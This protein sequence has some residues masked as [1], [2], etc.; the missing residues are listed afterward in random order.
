M[1]PMMFILV[2]PLAA[3][4]KRNMHRALLVPEILLIIFKY[5]TDDSGN[6]LLPTLAAI[7]RTCRP[8]QR[9]VEEILWYK[10][11]NI[12]ALYNILPTQV[13][14]RES[15]S[16]SLS[17]RMLSGP[18]W[19]RFVDRAS[20]VRVLAENTG[21]RHDQYERCLAIF[22]AMVALRDPLLLTPNLR[23]LE[24]QPS[25]L[26]LNPAINLF[27]SPSLRSLE[28][29]AKLF[30]NHVI[31]LPLVY[32][33]PKLEHL[34]ITGNGRSAANSISS[35]LRGLHCLET[36]ACSTMDN[37]AFIHLAQL[38]KLSY[39][40]VDMR[41]S[42]LNLEGLHDRLPPGSFPSLQTLYWK[43]YSIDS[44]ADIF[45]MPE[46]SPSNQFPNTRDFSLIHDVEAGR[47]F[48]V[49]VGA[50]RREHQLDACDL[51]PLSALKSLRVL[52]L[53]DLGY[54]QLDD[55][56]I[57]T[58][59]STSPELEKLGLGMNG[60]DPMPTSVTFDGLLSLLQHCPK[61]QSLG[62]CVDAED[63]LSFWDTTVRHHHVTH[64]R[65]EG[66][67]LGSRRADVDEMLRRVL[68]GLRTVEESL[69]GVTWRVR[70]M[71][72]LDCLWQMNPP[73]A[74]EREIHSRV[75][76]TDEVCLPICIIA[77]A[78]F[79]RDPPLPDVFECCSRMIK[80][81][82]YLNA[83]VYPLCYI[84]CTAVSGYGLFFFFRM[85]SLA[86]ESEFVFI[87]NNA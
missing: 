60:A 82:L 86:Q 17:R 46:I 30:I 19:T 43:D 37:D 45:L 15:R 81:F 87:G 84:Q 59:A 20:R 70:D 63:M 33:C 18:D 42:L 49:P 54:L 55:D 35:V 80:L 13:R 76:A 61:L 24:W 3:A 75:P 26:S 25:H 2:P 51:K 74:D 1:G 62:L 78:S 31:R 73:L 56:L 72:R 34:K 14:K 22:L 79:L 68:P 6:P 39:L 36:V 52:N 27:I 11:P 69:D 4:R 16:W 5:V 40:A 44:L 66:S 64:L 9:Q 53:V 28:I 50:P 23:K 57:K 21:S 41:W 65:L 67:I 12:S 83:R 38:K 47:R 77:T 85:L 8:F 29:D 32:I 71:G 58:I 10:L 7:A 48:G